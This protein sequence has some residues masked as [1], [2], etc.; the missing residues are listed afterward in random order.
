MHSD[1]SDTIIVV[2]GLMTANDGTRQFYVPQR[3][4]LYE[5][6]V[7]VFSSQVFVCC[8]SIY[9]GRQ[10]CGNQLVSHR[11]KVTQE[12]GHTGFRHLLS[13]V[14]LVLTVIFIARRIQQSL[15]LSTV[16][17]NFVYPRN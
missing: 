5:P 6:V 12:E 3:T 15:P 1:F 4:F 16:K 10:S 14:V 13:S 2:T 11:R 17:S 7:A 9:A 8:H